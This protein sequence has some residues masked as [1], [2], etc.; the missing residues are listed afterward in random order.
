M[1]HRHRLHGLWYPLELL[2]SAT[3]GAASTVS[4]S[5]S[6]ATAHAFPSASKSPSPAA[7]PVAG[8]VDRDLGVVHTHQQRLR[9]KSRVQLLFKLR[10]LHDQGRRKLDCDIY[11]FQH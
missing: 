1:P 10:A 6:D 3:I 5:A 9:R 8:D 2:T 7:A 11:H 4:A